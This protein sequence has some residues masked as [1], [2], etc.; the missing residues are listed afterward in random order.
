MPPLLPHLVDGV[1]DREF[2]AGVRLGGDAG[3][4]AAVVAFAARRPRIAAVGHRAGGRRPRCPVAHSDDGCRAAARG[5]EFRPRHPPCARQT[6]NNLRCEIPSAPVDAKLT[7]TPFSNSSVVPAAGTSITPVDPAA[8]RSCTSTGVP[9]GVG[10][11]YLVLS[12]S[13]GA[14]ACVRRAGTGCRESCRRQHR[15]RQR[16]RELDAP[17]RFDDGDAPHLAGGLRELAHVV[18]D[19]DPVAGVEAQHVV[20]TQRLELQLVGRDHARDAAAHVIARPLERGAGA[21]LAGI[22]DFDPVELVLEPA[23]AAGRRQLAR[24]VH[25]SDVEGAGA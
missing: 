24:V 3:G 13:S 15:G 21:G 16:G 11:E 20:A 6:P 7:V 10:A 1:L 4:A 12:D 2:A 8:S 5:R 17:R 23:V 19:F 18:D 22:M 25:R 14:R 9:P